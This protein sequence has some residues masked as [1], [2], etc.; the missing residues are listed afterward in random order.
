VSSSFFQ[1]FDTS[2]KLGY[3]MMLQVSMK[4]GSRETEKEI[5]NN[6]NQ[7]GSKREIKF[8]SNSS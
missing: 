4:D 3:F 1:F 5:K 8:K 7:V 6:Q 2:F